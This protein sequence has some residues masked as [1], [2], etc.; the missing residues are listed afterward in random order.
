MFKL[1][2][3]FILLAVAVNSMPSEM[4][5]NPEEVA[6]EFEG[7]IILTEADFSRLGRSGI[8]DLTKRWTKNSY[9]Q[10]VIPYA[11]RAASPY[12]K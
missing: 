2:A 4:L 1:F 3:I 9:K 7:D 8:L 12:S 6:G 5:R 11:F 10:V